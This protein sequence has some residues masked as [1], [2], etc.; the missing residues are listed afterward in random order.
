[1]KNF[2]QNL[3]SSLSLDSSVSIINT[4]GE[5]SRKDILGAIKVRLGFG[6]KNYKVNPGLYSVGHPNAESE[7]FVTAN[8]KLSFDTLR[9]NLNG[10]NAWILVLDTKGINVWCAA[11]KGTFGT[12]ELIR[13]I[14][15]TML[16]QRVSHKRLILPQLG[17]PGISA[18]QILKQTGFYVKYGPVR[19]CDIPEYLKLNKSKTK[20]MRQVSFNFIDRLTLIPVEFMGSIKYLLLVLA[21]FFLLSGLDKSGY[22]TQKLFSDGSVTLILVAVA[23]F[24]GVFLFPLLLPL[25]PFRSFS[26]KGTLLGVIIA[27]ILSLSLGIKIIALFTVA[28]ILLFTAITSFLAMNFTGATTFTSL[29]GV[30]K[31]MKFAV[32]A[33]LSALILSS[34]LFILSRFIEL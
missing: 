20:Q 7:I 32:P 26:A 28:L 15:S 14:E 2:N 6:R 30:Q 13:Q 8:Y 23:Y 29:S 27:L 4:T 19:A 16:K 34:L 31:E 17:A 3:L 11:G 1:M 24:T 9:K 22:L 12:Q 5:L 21:V 18:D 25:I 10:I 33:Q